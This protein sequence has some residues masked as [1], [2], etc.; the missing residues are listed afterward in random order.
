MKVKKIAQ[1]A[2]LSA[3]SLII[4]VLESYI[5]PLVA[6]PGVKLG[7]ANIITL[8]AMITLGRKT[9]FA[10]LMIKI[11][12]GNLLTGSAVSLFYSFLGGVLC[13]VAEVTIYK[14]L[15]EEYVWAISVT[16][17]IFHNIGQIIAATILLGTDKIVWYLTIL[18]PAGILTGAFTGICTSYTLKATKKIKLQ[19]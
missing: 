8:Y 12:L 14:L 6:I 5:P 15:S 7:M 11:L 16:G 2:V 19:R 1:A 13:F 9:A 18:I 10:V 4:F 3:L 17:A